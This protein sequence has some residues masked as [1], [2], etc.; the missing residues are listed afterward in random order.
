MVISLFR[1]LTS[2]ASSRAIA[3]LVAAETSRALN[4]NSG[5][6]ASISLLGPCRISELLTASACRPQTSLER[7]RRDGRL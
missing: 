2:A 1:S 3:I 6:L 4:I 5:V 7:D